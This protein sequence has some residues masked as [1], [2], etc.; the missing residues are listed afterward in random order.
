M[1]NFMVV[2]WAACR[3]RVLATGSHFFKNGKV[4]TILHK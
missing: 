4:R 1:A 2:K 3:Y